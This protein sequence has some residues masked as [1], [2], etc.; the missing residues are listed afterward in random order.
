MTETKY[1]K[2]Q[3]YL[4]VF[5]DDTTYEMYCAVSFKDAVWEMVKYTHGG[6]QRLFLTAIK[7]AE[8]EEEIVDIYN[9]F[10]HNT[11]PLKIIYEIKRKLTVKEKK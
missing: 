1:T 7:G 2:E 10:F 9:T 5:E 3:C 4:F 6:D 11:L 8:T